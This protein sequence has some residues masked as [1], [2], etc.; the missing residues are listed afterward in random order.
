MWLEKHQ[1]DLR[2]EDGKHLPSDKVGY[3]P[4]RQLDVIHAELAVAT[5]LGTK[6]LTWMRP[7]TGDPHTELVTLHPSVVVL[8]SMT[9][10]P[11]N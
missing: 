11:R 5:V 3:V 6:L 1:K 8:V 2:D 10:Q 7:R 9:L 4:T